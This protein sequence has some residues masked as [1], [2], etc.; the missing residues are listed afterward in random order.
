MTERIYFI[1]NELSGA[2]K[3]G[4]SRKPRGRLANL[5]AATAESLTLL[6][7]IPGGKSREKEL[8]A[9]WAHLRKSGEWF[10]GRAELLAAISALVAEEGVEAIAPKFTPSPHVKLASRWINE[11]AR[12]YG[13]PARDYAQIGRML[14]TTS[15]IVENIRRL[16]LSRLTSEE[17]ESIKKHFIE[18]LKLKIEALQIELEHA[19]SA[20]S[21]EISASELMEVET[22]LARL[23]KIVSRW[24]LNSGKRNVGTA[25]ST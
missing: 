2:V 13:I 12:S 25:N 7:V 9:R 17:F 8:H 18:L 4:Y 16:R 21:R 14:G 23:Q 6:G 19:R 3:I 10:D 22:D 24:G 11:I 1:R 15:G 5:R 20:R